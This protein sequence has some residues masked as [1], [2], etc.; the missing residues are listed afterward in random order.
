MRETRFFRQA[1]L[2]VQV[3][4]F[5]NAE[6][7]F[8]L[9]GGTAINFFV[10]D[11]PRLSVDI[12][13]VYLPVEDR[14][15]TLQGIDAALQRIAAKIRRAMP[16]VQV[17][18]H[19]SVSDKFLV[20]LTVRAADG[21]EVKIEPNT[22]LRGTLHPT[23]E[24]TL[25]PKAV[26][27]FGRS[28]TMRVVSLPDLFGGKLCAALDRQHPRD[29]FDVHGLFQAEG[30]TDDIRR[31]FVVFLASHDRPMS[32]LLTP[33]RKDLKQVFADQFEGMTLDPVPLAVLEDTRERLI[34]RINADLT[35]AEREFLLSMKRLAPKW[36][37]LG[38]PGVERLPGPQW[39]LYNLRKMDAAKRRAA[40]EQ[41]RK[42]LGL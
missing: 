33:N 25:S 39:K 41:L 15:T 5:V 35:A 12:D 26:E 37:L 7:C 23:T 28:A 27:L 2:L 13:L 10:R 32:E 24:L 8:A 18:E 9:K 6:A 19:R 34:E 20:K 1:D 40:E 21:A 22:V 36:E 16:S 11:F 29:L 30:I 4:P 14:A 31:A 38:L 17:R 3:M 42:R